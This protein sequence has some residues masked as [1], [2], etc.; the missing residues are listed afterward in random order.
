MQL[1]L[2]DPV[3]IGHLKTETD[4]I[5]RRDKTR[6]E[7]RNCRTLVDSGSVSVERAVAL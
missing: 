1:D 3:G 4:N 6:W 5:G 7:H 2:M